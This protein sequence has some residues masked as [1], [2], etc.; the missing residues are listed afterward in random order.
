LLGGQAGAEFERPHLLVG[1]RLA[2][3]LAL[4]IH[5]GDRIPDAN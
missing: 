5:F 3:M 1:Q 4:K 2:R